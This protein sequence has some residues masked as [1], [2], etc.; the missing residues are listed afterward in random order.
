LTFSETGRGLVARGEEIVG[1]NVAG[2]DRKFYPAHARIIGPRKMEV[3]SDQVSPPVAVRYGWSNYTVVN[4]F[5][6]AGL[7]MTPFR[8]DDWP[9]EKPFKTY[10]WPRPK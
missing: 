6:Q 4:M 7:P 10:P 8:T 3:W 1:F 9:A 2:S 5:N